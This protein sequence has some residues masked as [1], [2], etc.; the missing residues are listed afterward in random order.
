MKGGRAAGQNRPGDAGF[1]APARVAAIAYTRSQS[2]TVT[3][4]YRGKVDF[5]EGLGEA[6]PAP[7][8]IR[9]KTRGDNG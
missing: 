4:Q 8:L 3:G 1:G 5:S 7:A 2:E 6:E 9:V